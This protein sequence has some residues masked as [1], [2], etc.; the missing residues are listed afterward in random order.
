MSLIYITGISGTGKT[1]VAHELKKRGFEAYDADGDGFNSWYDKKTGKKT[2]ESSHT[3]T[4]TLNWYKKHIWRTSRGKI[5]DLAIHAK[6]KNM[7]ICGTPSNEKEIWDL[8]SKVI[9]LTIDEQTL[10]H[11]IRIRSTNEFGKAPHELT[12]I[13]KWY[14]LNQKLYKQFGA[15][16][17][18][19]TKPL[20]EV[21]DEILEICM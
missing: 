14:K 12:E 16:I 3:N 19:A 18:D 15:Y 9:C 13:L 7:F 11:R 6:N 17:V 20:N 2:T 10:R 1:T 8:F 4:N 5:E 21:V